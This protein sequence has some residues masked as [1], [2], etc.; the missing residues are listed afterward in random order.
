VTIVLEN[1]LADLWANHT[2]RSLLIS[3]MLSVV[4]WLTLR[5]ATLRR[6][7]SPS[8]R[9]W[10]W[11]LVCLRFA[12]AFAPS[13]T[14]AFSVPSIASHWLIAS[15]PG[16]VKTLPHYEAS[17]GLVAILPTPRTAD[18]PNPKA[19]G[20]ASAVTGPP[21]S[22]SDR[23]F[24]AQRLPMRTPIPLASLALAVWTLGSLVRL[25]LIAVSTSQVG[26]FRKFG[27]GRLRPISSNTLMPPAHSLRDCSGL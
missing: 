5:P 3:S 9:F 12:L 22:A 19:T 20:P 23:D 27:A 8:L 15:A 17:P 14:I 6:M 21:N 16:S 18:V 11:W 13:P 26:S 10:L 7:L 24:Q 4:L 25:L 2:L 1:V